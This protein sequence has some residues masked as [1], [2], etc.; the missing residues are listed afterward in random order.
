MTNT[1]TPLASFDISASVLRV[2]DNFNQYLTY[3]RSRKKLRERRRGG[4]GGAGTGTR[5][6]VGGVIAEL[7]AMC[8]LGV[9]QES[10]CSPFVID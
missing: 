1:H 4:A 9:S 7:R 3:R 5:D 2:I 10:L 6:E 8:L